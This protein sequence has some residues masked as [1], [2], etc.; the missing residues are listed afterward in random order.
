MENYFQA[1]NGLIREKR[2]FQGIGSSV[3]IADQS[4]GLRSTI[5]STILRGEPGIFV[6]HG[7]TQ[8]SI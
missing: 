2:Y 8:V 1:Q 3:A 6:F 5:S 4:K 7:N